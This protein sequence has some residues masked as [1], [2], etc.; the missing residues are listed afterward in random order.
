[1]RAELQTA[2]KGLPN[3]TFVTLQRVAVK[4]RLTVELLIEA[5]CK[6]PIYHR[7]EQACV[8]QALEDLGELLCQEIG[9]GVAQV[10][11][12]E[13][14][15]WVIMTGTSSLLDVN[16]AAALLR[17]HVTEADLPV[18]IELVPNTVWLCVRHLG[19]TT[20]MR[21]ISVPESLRA[22]LLNLVEPPAAETVR[23]PRP[24]AEEPDAP[25]GQEGS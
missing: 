10:P 20:P 9:K 17:Q 21:D 7:V 5:V 18:R 24:K 15:A 13:P 23:K 8:E 11:A 19:T 25:T 1:M 22:A 4:H 16:A 14:P 2:L 12:L 3:S 6:R